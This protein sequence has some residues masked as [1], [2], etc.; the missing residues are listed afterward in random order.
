MVKADEMKCNI[1]ATT[2]E[3]HKGLIDIHGIMRCEI[4]K[5]QKP[6]EPDLKQ[7]DQISNNCD[8][9]HMESKSHL[10]RTSLKFAES[11]VDLKSANEGF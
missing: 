6:Y 9:N 1:A 10:D 2:K 11:T 8:G 3:A 4:G 5:D 7:V